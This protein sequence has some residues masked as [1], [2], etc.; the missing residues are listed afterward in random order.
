MPPSRELLARH[1]LAGRFSVAYV[2]TLGLAHGLGTV[3]EAAA[4]LP[5]VAFLFIGDGADR[6]RLEAEARQRGLRNVHFTGLLPRAEIPQWLASLDVL[7][8]MLRDLAV[9]ETVIPSKIFEYLAQ[10]RPVI[11]AA[12]KRGEIRAMIEEAGAGWTIDPEQPGQ[13]AEAIERIRT[14]PEEARERARRGREWVERDFRREA[15]ACRMA[16]FLAR[17]AAAR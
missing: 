15:L 13:L 16:A 9:F 6:A 10:E 17:V 7:L 5:D 8:V 11:L 3:L 2:G 1:G 12:P 14:H 4:R